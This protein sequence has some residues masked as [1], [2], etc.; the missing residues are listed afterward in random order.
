MVALMCQC[1]QERYIQNL[2]FLKSGVSESSDF[3]NGIEYY[4]YRLRFSIGSFFPSFPLRFCP[5][6]E[7]VTDFFLKKSDWTSSFVDRKFPFSSSDCIEISIVKFDYF[8]FDW[9]PFA[10]GVGA[11]KAFEVFKIPYRDFNNP[12]YFADL[13]MERFSI[14]FSTLYFYYSRTVKNPP[15]DYDKQYSYD[16]FIA[17]I[18]GNFLEIFTFFK[19]GYLRYFSTSSPTTANSQFFYGS[20]FKYVIEKEP[21]TNANL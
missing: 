7:I 13:I 8:G 12:Q 2:V 4:C 14:L 5:F 16:E 18:R 15:S 10:G 11:D 9:R 20:D 3:I 6:I 21:H 19:S 1:C 17:D